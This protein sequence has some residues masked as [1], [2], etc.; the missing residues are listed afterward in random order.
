MGKVQIHSCRSKYHHTLLRKPLAHHTYSQSTR[1]TV[2]LKSKLLV[3]FHFSPD[4]R[5]QASHIDRRESEVSKELQKWQFCIK[6]QLK[7]FP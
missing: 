7:R 6:L 1:Q 2:L 3:S 4:N 5:K